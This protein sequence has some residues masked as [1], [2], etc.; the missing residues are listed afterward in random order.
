MVAGKDDVPNIVNNTDEKENRN[1]CRENTV[2]I[3]L[4]GSGLINAVVD[5]RVGN[6]SLDG[7]NVK[8]KK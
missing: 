8:S 2:E 1:N 5:D 7:G 4:G 6:D 3:I